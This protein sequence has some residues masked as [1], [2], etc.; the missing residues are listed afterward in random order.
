MVGVLKVYA[1][2]KEARINRLNPDLNLV[3]QKLFF[4]AV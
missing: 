2:H 3:C 1:E 4:V